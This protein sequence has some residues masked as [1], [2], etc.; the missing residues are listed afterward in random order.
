MSEGAGAYLNNPF[1]ETGGDSTEVL[2]SQAGTGIDLDGFVNFIKSFREDTQHTNPSP[3]LGSEGS[4]PQ[5]EPEVPI[6][7]PRL[8]LPHLLLSE[9]WRQRNKHEIRAEFDA[10]DKH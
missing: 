3:L 10:A 9:P 7:D 5:G 6:S 8:L 4:P 2:M 1:K